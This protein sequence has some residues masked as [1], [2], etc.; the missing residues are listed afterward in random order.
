MWILIGGALA[1]GAYDALKLRDGA[2]CAAL[3]TGPEVRDELIALAEGDVQ[4][5]YVSIRAADC[6]IAGFA[7]DAVVI[8]RASAWVADPDKAG[9]AIV[10]ASGVDGFTAEGAL[11]I[12]RAAL[13]GPD[14]GMRA[15]MIRRLARSEHLDVRKVVDAAEAVR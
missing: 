11:T 7:V 6:L 4:P 1:G 12:A 2:D 8:E 9:L 5:G 3:G 14:A 15:R 13:A 10:V